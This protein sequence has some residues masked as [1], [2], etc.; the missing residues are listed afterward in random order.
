MFTSIASRDRYGFPFETGICSVCGNVQQSKYYDTETLVDFYTNYYRDIYGSMSGHELFVH[1]FNRGKAVYEFVEEHCGDVKRVLEVGAGAGGIIKR[2][3]DK[4]HQVVGV[5]Y[6]QRYEEYA[7]TKGVKVLDGGLDALEGESD[8]YDLVIVCHVLEHIVDP[9][10]FLSQLK[11]RLSPGG[12]IFIEVPVIDDL[13]EGAYRGE[14]TRYL[15]NAHVVH[16]TNASLRKLLEVQSL[17]VL[18]VGSHGR[19][20]VADAGDSSRNES[21]FSSL[22]AAQNSLLEKVLDQE[23]N[24]VSHPSLRNAVYSIYDSVNQFPVIKKVFNAIRESRH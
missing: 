14:F 15:Q 2:F 20:L 4:G 10:D 22:R 24:L 13:L 21:A 9:A 8:K 6:D 18:K 1:Q 12:M 7:A 17:Q 19:V 23:R 16:Y 11:M 5:D 3:Q